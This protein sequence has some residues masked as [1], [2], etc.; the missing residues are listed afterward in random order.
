MG[1]GKR[2]I[3]LLKNYYE[4]KISCVNESTDDFQNET[5]DNCE[6]DDQND[7]LKEVIEPRRSVPT[8]LKRLNERKPEQ[9]D[10]LGTRFDNLLIQ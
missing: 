5:I 4:G 7:L 9:L 1:Y 6:R 8:L 3:Q 2:A 10:Y